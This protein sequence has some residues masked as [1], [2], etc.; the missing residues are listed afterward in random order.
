MSFLVLKR[1]ITISINSL[2]CWLNQNAISKF[3]YGCPVSKICSCA[4]RNYSKKKRHAGLLQIF[5][6]ERHD[7]HQNIST[8]TVD[9]IS[10]FKLLSSVFKHLKN[11][12]TQEQIWKTTFRVTFVLITFDQKGLNAKFELTYKLKSCWM[13]WSSWSSLRYDINSY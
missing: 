5:Y 10:K 13:S 2:I 3:L 6:E 7:I 8:W 1:F 4:H 9:K 12:M 11:T